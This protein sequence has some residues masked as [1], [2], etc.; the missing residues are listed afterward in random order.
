MLSHLSSLDSTAFMNDVSN[1]YAMMLSLDNK[2]T[3]SE[4]LCLVQNYPQ[5]LIQKPMQ[6]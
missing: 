4:Y 1:P 6:T 5:S 2:L 3:I